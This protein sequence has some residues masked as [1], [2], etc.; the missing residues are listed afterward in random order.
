[1]SFD[2]LGLSADILRAVAEQGYREPTPVQRQ[3]IP[4]VLA[5]RDLMASAQ[6]GTG[7]T[8][9]F[10]LPLL[11]LLSSNAPPAKGRRPVRALILTPT[12][13]LAAQIDENVRAYSKY[14]RLRS[15]VVFGGVSINPQMMKLRGGVDILVATPG[16]L[17][18]LEHQNAVDLSQ[19]EILVLDEADRMLDMGFIHDIRRVL[20]KLPAKRQNLLFSA[21]FSD[22]IKTLAGK[23]LT[24]PASVEVVRRNTPSELV[25]QH[26]H[27]V[28][29][30]RKRELLSQLVGEN[31]WQ[32]VL[33]FTRTKHG[34]NHLAELLEKDGI[35][36]AA[37]HGNKSQGAR[38][39]ALANF[40]DGTIRVL[41][42]TDIAARGLDIDQL[43]HVVNYELPNVPE[44]Y[45]H[46]I[47]RTGRAEST[48][49]ALSLVC[50]DEHKLLRDIERLLN[51]E[52]PRI[53]VPG[54]EPDPSIKAEPIINGRQGNRGGGRSGAPRGQSD[55]K[56]A[57]GARQPR[58][59]SGHGADGQRRSPRPQNRGKPAAR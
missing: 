2:S 48:G 26:V 38:T 25:T 9:G 5:G 19:I 1:M 40:K 20:A 34:A 7:K 17:L 54:Y 55:R 4:V 56:P 50:V 58:K 12:R 53:A 43:P 46:R 10:T 29:K 21:T 59:T 33:V 13:E 45:V 16:R 6:T 49:E 23:L 44:D 41:V 14:L 11:Q 24:N 22:E 30:R 36:A 3:A 47:G 35:T 27:F 31:N 52:I 18:D 37:I 28:D 15:L 8:A 39:R 32:Q 51:R 42:A 57:D